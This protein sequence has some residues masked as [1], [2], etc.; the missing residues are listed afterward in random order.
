LKTFITQGRE[1]LD[2]HLDAIVNAK[3]SNDQGTKREWETAR[4]IK[5]APQ[6]K[7]QPITPAGN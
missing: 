1:V 2:L 5:D 6:A 3:Y 7:E 4:N